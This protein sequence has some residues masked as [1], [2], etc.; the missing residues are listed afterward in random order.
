MQ[1]IV[2]SAHITRDAQRR[3]ED[4]KEKEEEE[5]GG[6]ETMTRQVSEREGRIGGGEEREE[7][8]KSNDGALWCDMRRRMR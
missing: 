7:G 8:V 6:D 2:N 4:G 5:E 3:D 1:T